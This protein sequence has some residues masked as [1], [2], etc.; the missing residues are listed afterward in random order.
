MS[1]SPSN[2]SF[3]NLSNSPKNSLKPILNKKRNI[4]LL[5]R[6]YLIR[7]IISPHIDYKNEYEK[8]S[9]LYYLLNSFNWNEELYSKNSIIE[10]LRGNS[11]WFY[12]N[13][14]YFPFTS[15]ELIEKK[16]LI[17]DIIKKYIIERQSLNKGIY[18]KNSPAPKK[19]KFY[20]DI[21]S[22]SEVLI[23]NNKESFL[24]EIISNIED[25]LKTIEKFNSE[26]LINYIKK[27][28]LLIEKF[29]NNT[30]YDEYLRMDMEFHTKSINKFI[31]YIKNLNESRNALIDP[32]NAGNID[33]DDV[34]CSICNDGDY[35]DD[36]LIVYCSIC[37]ITVH[38][39][40]YGITVVPKDDWICHSCLA[41]NSVNISNNI[42]C[43]LCSCKGGAMKPC[44]LKKSSQLYK[45]LMS[46]RN[47]NDNSNKNNSNIIS[48]NNTNNNNINTNN[49]NSNNNNNNI[50]NNNSNT[51]NNN[52]NVNLPENESLT[53]TSSLHNNHNT[54]NEF[55]N[56][57]IANEHAWIHMSC[58]LWIPEIDI[59]N[60]KQKEK[61]KGIET[62]HKKRFMEHCEICLLSGYGPTIKCE[63]CTLRFHVECARVNKFQLEIT[64]NQMG[65][66]KFHVFCQRH[67]PHKLV[68][69]IELKKQ[70]EIDDIKQFSNIIEKNINMYNKDHKNSPLSVYYKTKGEK[71]N[72]I[73]NND[74]INK[75]IKLNNKE[76]KMF[77]NTIRQLESE[78]SNLTIEVNKDD[79]SIIEKKN[80]KNL[81]YNDTCL[82]YKFPWYMIKDSELYLNG[83][84]PIE[85]FRLYQ[86][87]IPNEMAYLK[88]IQKMSNAKLQKL[89][90][91]QKQKAKEK[92]KEIK[93]ENEDI[94][95]Y[96]HKDSNLFMVGCEMKEKCSH[97]GWYHP[98]C[99]E[100]LKN[101]PEDYFINDDFKYYCPDCRNKFG[102]EF[103]FP[104]YFKEDCLNINQDNSGN[105]EKNSN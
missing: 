90:K 11:L 57:K 100:E 40:C 3:Q 67:A 70:R 34:V 8:I 83:M 35:E 72:G 46:L 99:V 102:I 101:F 15:N 20:N 42:E 17:P 94:Y 26:K 59:S 28:F 89:I 14:M 51:N 79:F 75:K 19:F 62:I 45:T 52:T 58:A 65:E 30:S 76:K 12:F 54:I 87:I 13:S 92:N 88:I 55:I 95:C 71:V 10:N 91:Q 77:L 32:L 24:D 84:K 37:H 33:P 41:Y 85:I 53:T 69:T 49:I 61:I 73:V 68:K 82:A 60:Y 39:R 66:N 31:E 6:N 81:S 5:Q 16:E 105:N 44:S 104:P 63:K 78:I 4:D 103:S 50:N 98:K 18:K 9:N 7:R 38:Q 27:K 96:C 97:N 56:E 80:K 2:S 25:S 43:I 93:Y 86:S 29:D 23:K 36:N 48:T 74:I 22:L 47:Q 64:D 21:L 1:F